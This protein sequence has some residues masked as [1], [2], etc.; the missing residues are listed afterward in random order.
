[1]E[2]IVN[3]QNI[4]KYAERLT[5]DL[6]RQFFIN[7]AF[8]SG[9]EI[10]K[11]NGES[12]LN[13][14]VIKN[15]Y[16]NWLKETSRLKSIYFDYEDEE[17]KQALANFMNI[18]SNHIK[19]YRS[20]FEVLLQK[21][22][23]DF[24]LLSAAPQTFFTKECEVLAGPKISLQLL[25][26]FSKYIKVNRFVMDQV[27]RE[28]EASGYTETFGGETIRF[29]MKALNENPGKVENPSETLA[30]LFDQLPA[31]VTEFVS[32]PKPPVTRPAFLDVPREE[33]QVPEPRPVAPVV[34]EVIQPTTQSEP[35]PT[36]LLSNEESIEPELNVGQSPEIQ[37]ES[38]TQETS[39]VEPELSITESQEDVPVE[40]S[41]EV[42]QKLEPVI[43]ENSQPKQADV[44]PEPIMEPVFVA[45]QTLEAVETA[46]QTKV[47]FKTL[48]PMHYRFTFINALFGGNQQAWAEAVDKIDAANSGHEAIA[49]LKADYGQTYN[50]D[51]EEDN[52]GILS[53]YIERKF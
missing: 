2:Y 50:W 18:L 8:I 11:F 48:V 41:P 28:I 40:E 19:V 31:R 1:M 26:E 6:C 47:P 51:K 15:I 14:L 23:A 44:L 22:I 33:Y 53:N 29:V 27:I 12:Q 16:L 46:T 10:L 5:N 38:L 32:T 42:F 3:Q 36:E 49:R 7:K 34:E 37:D 45:T 9:P 4:Q 52:V 43:L 21:S 25:K 17:V 13:L 24:I 35:A 30:G 20:D 39:Q